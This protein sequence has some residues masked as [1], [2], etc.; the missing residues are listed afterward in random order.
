MT[1]KRM[2]ATGPNLEEK[3]HMDFP[4]DGAA[5]RASPGIAQCCRE[6]R[7]K[8]TIARLAKKAR[9][10]NRSIAVIESGNLSKELQEQ[11]GKNT[12][13]KMRAWAS[14]L[15]KLA[16]ALEQDP[17]EWLERAEIDLPESE[18][19]EIKSAARQRTSSGARTE[20]DT[21]STLRRELQQARPDAM[22]PI[23]VH[24][25][26]S[27]KSTRGQEA[28]Y[29]RFCK[30]L[31][32]TIDPR[33]EPRF[34]NEVRTFEGVMEGLSTAP[35]RH[36]LV[37]GA[38]QMV[39]R[40]Q[41]RVIFI[42]IPGWRI[43]LGALALPEAEVTW[44][45]IRQSGEGLSRKAKQELKILVINHEAADVY[46]RSFCDFDEEKI[47]RIN[48]YHIR[49]AAERFN[50]ELEKNNRAVFVLGDYEAAVMRS[51]LR[52]KY[53]RDL[54]DI[55]AASESAPRYQ[56]ALVVA[57]SDERW[58]RTLRNAIDE[59]FKNAGALMAEVY[60]QYMVDVIDETVKAEAKRGHDER[61]TL[62]LTLGLQTAD[63]ASGNG[64]SR[65]RRR[66]RGYSRAALRSITSVPS[67]L[68][69][70]D[71]S[72]PVSSAFQHR[73]HDFLKSELL[74]LELVGAGEPFGPYFH[75]LAPWLRSDEEETLRTTNQI[76][77]QMERM[78]RVQET[79]GELLQQLVSRL[80]DLLA[81]PRLAVP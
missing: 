64:K 66:Q 60:G 52:Q 55:A 59:L 44:E 21:L 74:R 61:E 13:R 2:D 42:P 71:F 25:L 32:R 6:A 62:R 46:L 19:K 81:E 65:V 51:I 57:E 26:T 77:R 11:E 34:T 10:S 17:D 36:R 76:R 63:D 35:P 22:I 69:L 7:G 1:A 49:G 53:K 28:F 37:V 29:N 47:L 56:L 31:L 43:R 39:G 50:E 14:V 68:Q 75:S 73:L 8:T 23:D 40:T 80:D 54:V 9:V 12:D 30:L 24:L 5:V 3:A 18:L 48:E 33:I 70:R 27:D 15:T 78:A 58:A 41:H 20:P 67:Y 72:F 45:N 4:V 79:H 38:F 16:L